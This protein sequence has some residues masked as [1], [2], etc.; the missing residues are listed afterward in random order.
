MFKLKKVTQE[1]YDQMVKSA[2]PNSPTLKNCIFAF[3]IGGLICTLGQML[4][5]LY[6]DMGAE[7]KIARALVSV[8][9]VTIAIIV[10]AC[11]I[12][13]DIAKFAGAGTLIP[14]TGFANSMAA[15]AIE[16]KSEGHVAGIG[17]KMFSIAGPVLVYGL[18]ASVLYGIIYYIYLLVI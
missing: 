10:T 15:P 5:N 17:A 7:L 2:S 3:L 6:L 11:N 9:L 1:Q 14:I 8:T 13:D 16:F 12:Y 4:L 18:A